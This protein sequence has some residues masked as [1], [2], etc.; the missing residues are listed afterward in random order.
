MHCDTTGQAATS[1]THILC[2]STSSHLSY[3]A[4]NPTPIVS[5]P[6]SLSLVSFLCFYDTNQPLTKISSLNCPY[7]VPEQKIHGVTYLSYR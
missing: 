5:Q 2:W 7:R 4:S 6:P 1:H 3:S